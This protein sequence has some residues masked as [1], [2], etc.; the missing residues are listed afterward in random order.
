MTWWS[1]HKH[2]YVESWQSCDLFSTQTITG[3]QPG[4]LHVII[5]HQRLRMKLNILVLFWRGDV[6]LSIGTWISSLAN[7]NA[8][9]S[10]IEIWR[11]LSVNTQDK[12]ESTEPAFSTSMESSCLSILVWKASKVQV[13]YCKLHI[14]TAVKVSRKSFLGFRIHEFGWG[15]DLNYVK[16]N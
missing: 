1:G 3:N 7:S 5:P 16:P 15:R 9:L 10:T 12:I 4:V 8:K 6:L 2:K 14:V 13:K 11:C